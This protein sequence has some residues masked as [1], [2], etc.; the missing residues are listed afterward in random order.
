M[1]LKPEQ[2]NFRNFLFRFVFI[3]IIL[4]SGLSCT[5]DQ[6]W[7][8]VWSDEFKNTGLPDSAKWGYDVGGNG[9]GNNELE[10]YTKSCP[11]NAR[12]ENGKL[13]IT[14]IK[15]NY[16]AM[17][18]TSARLKTQGKASWK[19]GKIEARIKLPYGKGIWP[20][21]W[22][23]G[24]K[25]SA[26]GWPEC[27]EIDIMEMVGGTKGN[28][29]I[30]GAA[31][32]EKNGHVSDGGETSL[33]TGIFSDDFHIFAI[34]WDQQYI[35]WFLDGTMYHTI[36]ITPDGLSEFHENFFIILNLAVGGN[37]PG[38]PDSTTV[39]PQTMEV[40]YVRVYSLSN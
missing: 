30:H 19:Y 17:N 38:S 10:Y 9:W 22:M 34:E 14:A 26:V 35:K 12:I 3:L 33:S 32:W 15:E 29:T 36:D 39:F 8:L 20:A 40:D 21:F 37:W 28:N 5:H 7:S 27:G 11:E 4:F 25:F 31:H 24:N 13:I 1:C 18:Y 23:L 16:G 2:S 6:N